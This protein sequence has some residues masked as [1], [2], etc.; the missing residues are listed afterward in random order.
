MYNKPY[1]FKV[2]YFDV[3][4]YILY[5]RKT[6]PQIKWQNASI[7]N[8]ISSCLCKIHPLSELSY[9]ETTGLYFHIMD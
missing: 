1:P 3:I 8:N 6:S 5:S 2:Y 7:T 4:W 9:M